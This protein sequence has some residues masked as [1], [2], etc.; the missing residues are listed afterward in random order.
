MENNS[1]TINADVHRQDENRTNDNDIIDHQTKVQTPR[2]RAYSELRNE[3]VSPSKLPRI[4]KSKLV[5]AN[6]LTDEIETLYKE[7]DQQGKSIITS[8]L[9][10][11]KLKK[12]RLKETLSTTT[13]IRRHSLKRKN[14]NLTKIERRSRNQKSAQNLAMTLTN[15]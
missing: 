4:V 13:G 15:S 10:S 2:K 5:L 7:S 1:I 14:A 9:S 3:G 11:R 8:M 6:V 12:Y